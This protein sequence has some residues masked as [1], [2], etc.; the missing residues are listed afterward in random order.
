MSS[1]LFTAV[2]NACLDALKRRSVQLR[3]I[4][5]LHLSLIDSSA[6]WNPYQYDELLALLRKALSELPVD[7]RIAFEM[8]RFEGKTYK[9]IAIELG[10]SEKTVEYRI[11]QALKKLKKDLADYLPLILMVMPSLFQTLRG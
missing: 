1:Y 7:Q 3:A 11:S 4:S 6:D 8:N 10:I 9:E 2:R 5:D